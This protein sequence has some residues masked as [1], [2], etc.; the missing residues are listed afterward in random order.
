MNMVRV[1]QTLRALLSGGSDTTNVSAPS[2]TLP[3]M[4]AAA[5][6][7]ATA[8]TGTITT[9]A[10]TATARPTTTATT[11]TPTTATLA[12]T[13]HASAARATSASLTASTLSALTATHSAH[14][15]ILIG[16][17][18]VRHA[19]TLTYRQATSRARTEVSAA[20]VCSILN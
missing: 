10:L 19:D 2:T 9:T 18:L 15:L 11:W 3:G 4:S 8:A 6:L 1:A 17:V 14:A 20:G 13:T 12:P 5:G 7:G 16:A